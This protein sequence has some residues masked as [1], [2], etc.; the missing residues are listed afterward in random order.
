MVIG[1]YALPGKRS[2]DL[3]HIH[4][5]RS[6]GA[7]L[8]DINRKLIEVFSGGNVFVQA[9]M[10]GKVKSIASFE[11]TVVLSD[12]TAQMLLGDR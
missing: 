7:G 9:L 4:I 11:H 2:Q 6:T 1:V 8:K 3:I 5:G 10:T 12:V